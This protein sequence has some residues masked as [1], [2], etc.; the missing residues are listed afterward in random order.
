LLVEQSP[1]C[2]TSLGCSPRINAVQRDS[3]LMNKAPGRLREG[4]LLSFRRI[5]G[6]IVA[7]LISRI[8]LAI[9]LVVIPLAAPSG[10]A[11][12]RATLTCRSDFGYRA[13][14]DNRTSEARGVSGIF[15]LPP[16]GEIN[17]D[18]GMVS[19]SDV[20]LTDWFGN[21]DFVQIGWYVGE[22]G[23][24]PYA[25]P[26]T[27]SPRVFIGERTFGG[28]TYER[29][30]AGASLAW[31]SYH[32]FKLL[33]STSSGYYYFYVDGVYVGQ[34]QFKHVVKGMPGAVGEVQDVTSG[35]CVRMFGEIHRGSPDPDYKSLIYLTFEPSGAVW[36]YFNDFR[37]SNDS[38]RYR[39]DPF[40]GEQATAYLWGPLDCCG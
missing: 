8:L 1:D 17:V 5:Q 19:G 11:T 37:H 22:A 26:Y 13:W 7:R 14:D 38:N 21:G 35:N 34:S 15:K 39:A 24:D 10:P 32:V 23:E 33:Y 3:E 2:S 20:Y 29:L 12:A 31:G 27:S 36:H 16:Q 4:T 25:L 30:R 18:E 28:P 40:A 6:G 9:T